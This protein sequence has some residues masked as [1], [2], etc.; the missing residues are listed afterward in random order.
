MNP[1]LLAVL[2]VALTGA[3]ASLVLSSATSFAHARTGTAANRSAE[4]ALGA[5]ERILRTSIAQAVAAGTPDGP[6]VAPQTS[7]ATPTCAAI[8]GACGLTATIDSTLAGGTANAGASGGSDAAL[9]VQRD[10]AISE[11]RIAARLHVVVADALGTIVAQRTRDLT[12]RTYAIAPYV[13]ISATSDA[14]AA[15]NGDSAGCDGSAACAPHAVASPD[16]T[17]LHAVAQCRDDTKM[18]GKCTDTGLPTSDIGSASSTTQSWTNG[19][20]VSD[21]WKR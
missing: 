11:N 7:A 8:D 20:N 5:G 9:A 2:L 14:A 3:V 16:D 18:P 17:R 15:A 19:T 4:R 1:L 6:F 12:L 21:G 13:T 10:G